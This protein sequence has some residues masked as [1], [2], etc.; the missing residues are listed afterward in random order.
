MAGLKEYEFPK[1]KTFRGRCVKVVDGDTAD[2][3]LDLGFNV[4]TT[5]RVRLLEVNAYEMHSKVPEEVELAKTAKV[6][7]GELLV[8]DG[9]KWNL[10]VTVVKTEKYGRWLAYITTH[11]AP[12]QEVGRQLLAEGLVKKY[13]V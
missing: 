6:R 3:E 9:V 13:V 7:L 4:V 5:Q 1:L 8:N 10:A 12:M 11:T 2:L